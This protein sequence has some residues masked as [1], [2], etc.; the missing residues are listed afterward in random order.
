[1]KFWM[2]KSCLLL[3]Q[4]RLGFLELEDSRKDSQLRYNCLL[5]FLF[6]LMENL[7]FRNPVQFP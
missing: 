4:Y 3:C 5:S 1:M 2:L 6:K 7:G